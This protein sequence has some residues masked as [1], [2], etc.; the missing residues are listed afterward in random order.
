MYD[1]FSYTRT[2]VILLILGS[3]TYS[4]SST[5][6]PGTDPVYISNVGC[7]GSETN[8]LHCPHYNFIQLA[9]TTYCTHNRDVGL[10]CL[11]KFVTHL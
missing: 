11:R 3:T 7:V 8:L 9:S 4:S 2:R 1:N 6:G 10:K 5:F